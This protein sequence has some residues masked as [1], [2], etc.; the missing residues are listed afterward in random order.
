MATSKSTAL[1]V[2]DEFG[3]SPASVAEL[4]QAIKEEI[5]VMGALDLPRTH[6]PTGT[7][8]FW[9][10]KAT[11]DDQ[12]PTMEE[13]LEGV[14]VLHHPS[15][16]YFASPDP[17]PGTR[18]DC[19]SRDGITGVT[20]DGGEVIACA[21]CP[22]NQFGSGAK[23]DGSPGRGKACKNAHMLYMMREG[24]L[25]PLMVKI[26]PTGVRPLKS[27]LQGLLL[28]KN[29]ANPMRRPYEVV[30]RIMLNPVANVDGTAYLV[31]AFEAIGAL[32]AETAAALKRYGESFVGVEPVPDG[33]P[34][35]DLD[36]D[37]ADVF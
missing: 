6:V 24:E 11:A 29:R 8:P 28:P 34:G 33:I 30:T 1:A 14:I 4:A 9:P 22:H 25:L 27:Y 32:P 2:V 13:A 20:T 10:I 7:S 19:S 16:A 36:A 3:L 17:K 15:Y 18:P 12:R 5:G 37:A 35:E 23:A 21:T 26:P 31:P